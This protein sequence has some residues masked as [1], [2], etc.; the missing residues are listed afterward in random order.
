MVISIDNLYFHILGTK[1]F[2]SC[3]SKNSVRGSRLEDLL[4]T[5]HLESHLLP[6]NMNASYKTLSE[7]HIDTNKISKI[8]SI[9]RK[10]SVTFLAKWINTEK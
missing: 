3:I 2:Y 8:I 1:N 10:H 5:F 7:Q 6:Q 9:E 4:T